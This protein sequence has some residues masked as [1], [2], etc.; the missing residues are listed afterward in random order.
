MNATYDSQ[1]SP[2]GAKLVER[3]PGFKTT[4]VSF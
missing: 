4:T 3:N 2:D 1:Y